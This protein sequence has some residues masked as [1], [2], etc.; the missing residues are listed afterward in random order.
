[1]LK[2]VLVAVAMVIA[3][4]GAGRAES[5]LFTLAAT[6]PVQPAQAEQQNGQTIFGYDAQTVVTV[7]IGAMF[8]AAVATEIAVIGLGVYGYPA[9]TLWAAGSASFVGGALGGGALAN[10]ILEAAQAPR[11]SPLDRSPHGPAQA[12]ARR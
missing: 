9:A 4:A 12:N 6:G 11:T 3:L 5:R 8:G 2:T 10:W 7:T 1:M